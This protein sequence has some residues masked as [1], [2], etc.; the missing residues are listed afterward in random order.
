VALGVAEDAFRNGYGD[1]YL[2]ARVA[3]EYATLKNPD[4]AEKH[5]GKVGAAPA[6]FARNLVAGTLAA[7]GRTDEAMAELGNLDGEL[8]PYVRFN[9]LAFAYRIAGDYA[10]AEEMS[11]RALEI[12]R[13]EVILT[14]LASQYMDQER[15]GEAEPLLEEALRLSPDLVETH[16]QLGRSYA[17]SG[18]PSR[19]KEHLRAVLNSKHA[20]QKRKT[21]AGDLIARIER[22][23][24]ISAHRKEQ[25]LVSVPYG[26]LEQLKQRSRRQDTLRYE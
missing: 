12:R 25:N 14:T 23:E 17:F 10:R 18:K 21:E 15:Y 20:E 3:F 19:A 16:H 13:D 2:R 5:L 11:L 9:G 22:D 7:L 1:D 26:E 4:E 6:V 8:E 24:Q